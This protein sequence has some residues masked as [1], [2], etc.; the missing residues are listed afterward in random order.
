MPSF[1]DLTTRRVQYFGELL[2]SA[3][4]VGVPSAVTQAKYLSSVVERCPKHDTTLGPFSRAPDGGL[5][6]R[7]RVDQY[8]HRQ[9]IPSS[10]C[11][12]VGVQ[13]PRGRARATTQRDRYRRFSPRR[14]GSVTRNSLHLRRRRFLLRRRHHT[15]SRTTST[16]HGA[17]RMTVS[18]VLPSVNRESPVRP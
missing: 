10:R 2:G 18:A 7:A 16:E 3:D 15:V 17:D 11:L 5:N 14:T 6:S 12:K 4:S 8:G 9:A 1:R 13:S